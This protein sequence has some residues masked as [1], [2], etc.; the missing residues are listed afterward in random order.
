MSARGC[1]RWVGVGLLATGPLWAQ[2]QGPE[3]GLLRECFTLREQGRH[4]AAFERCSR[5]VGIARSSRSLAQLAI[6]EFALHRWNDAATHIAEALADRTNP[7]PERSRA[8]LAETMTQVRPHVAEL[9]VEGGEEGASVLINGAA[10]GTLPLAVPLYLQP[11]AVLLMVRPRQGAVVARRVTL[12]AGQTSTETVRVEPAGTAVAVVAPTASP[13][14]VAT[15]MAPVAPPPPEQ[16]ASSGS[17]R[18]VLAWTTAGVALAGFGLSLAA[19]RLR[20]GAVSDYVGQCPTGEIDDAMRVTECNGLHTRADTDVDQWGTIATVGLAAGG[21]LAVTSA[22]LFATGSG[23]RTEARA[24][25]CGGG[26]GLVGVGC[27]VAF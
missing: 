19:W 25:R 14:T 18:R 1:G 2:Q 13:A 8:V 9:R 27:T 7:L 11:G 16:R 12:T 22:V 21:V 3:E 17:T 26:P 4:D 6:T 15:V 5:A 23:A 10:V 20:E 24:V